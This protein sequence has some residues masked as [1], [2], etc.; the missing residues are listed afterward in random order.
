M[1]GWMASS[2][3][4]ASDR[5]ESVT[6]TVIAPIHQTPGC[7]NG[8]TSTFSSKECARRGDS[9]RA[10]AGTIAEHEREVGRR[11]ADAVR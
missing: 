10:Y 8:T 6:A 2:N 5:S 3:A 9:Y 1:I 4:E 7:V 11:A